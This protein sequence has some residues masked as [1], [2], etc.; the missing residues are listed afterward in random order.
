MLRGEIRVEEHSHNEW[1]QCFIYLSALQWSC[2]K[3]MIWTRFG[4]VM[5]VGWVS[6]QQRLLLPLLPL[7]QQQHQQKNECWKLRLLKFISAYKIIYIVNIK[8]MFDDA[9][10][11]TQSLKATL[12]QWKIKGTSPFGHGFQVRVSTRFFSSSSM[13]FNVANLCVSISCLGNH[14]NYGQ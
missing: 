12:V 3:I 6:L 4:N 2:P 9:H 5:H 1:D 7:Q 13:L 14:L 11:F 8:M 10:D